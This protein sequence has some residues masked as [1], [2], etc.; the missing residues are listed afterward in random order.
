[1]HGPAPEQKMFRDRTEATV[2]RPGT[3]PVPVSLLSLLTGCHWIV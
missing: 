3:L 1:L 2:F